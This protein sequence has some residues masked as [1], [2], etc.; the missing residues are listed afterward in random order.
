M[1]SVKKGFS[2]YISLFLSFFLFGLEPNLI[3]SQAFKNIQ[4]LQLNLYS[5]NISISN[6][7]GDEV[8]VELYS[9]NKKILPELQNDDATIFIKSDINNSSPADYCNVKIYIPEDKTFETVS[10]ICESG[11][12]F[13][14]QINSEEMILKTKSGTIKAQ[15]ISTPSEIIV[16]STSGTIDISKIETET[17]SA[18]SITGSIYI[19]SCTAEYF[20]A[21]TDSGFIDITL[22]RPQKAC[23]YLKSV[24]GDI[25]ISIGEKAGFDLIVFSNSGT[26]RDEINNLRLASRKEYRNS[27]FDGGAE[28]QV[29]TTSG[30][31]T[32]KKSF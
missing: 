27:Y 4:N 23:S 21:A 18:S 29:S 16:S 20:D 15:E 19:S 6:F 7:Y 17:M 1:V 25:Q 12:I 10:V 22:Q 9:N 3:S 32:L 14:E 31:I 8:L 28:L 26:F 13:I 5:E 2:L 11:N 24:S 30:N